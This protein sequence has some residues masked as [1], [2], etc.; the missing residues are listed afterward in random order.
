MRIN[1]MQEV[2]RVAITGLGIVSPLGN[3]PESFF[4]NLVAGN[5]GIKRLEAD[6]TDQLTTKIAAQASFDPTQHFTRQEL[7]L[8]DRVSQFALY[9]A[10]QALKDA[11]L[12]SET[13]ILSKAGVNM[14]ISLGGANTLDASYVRLYREG[15]NTLKPFTILMGMS[16]AA[17]SQIALKYGLCGPS[18]TYS[19]ACSS[20]SV[21]IGEAFRQIQHGYVDVM[22]AGGSE[23]QLTYGQI[24]AWEGLRALGQEDADNPA[25]S[26]K[27]F[28]ANRT[29]LVLGEGSA[30]LV[31]EELEH[32]KARG[33][34]IYAELSGYGIANDSAHITQPSVDGQ[35]AAITAALN[36]ASLEA[37]DIGYINA[38]GTGTLLND[39]TET[40][41]IKQIFGDSASA[42]PISSTKSMHGHLLGA[43]GAVELTATILAM[44]NST[45]P[46]TINL[47]QP[48][49]ACDLDYVPNTA[50]HDVEVRHAMSNSFA[51]GGTGVVLVISK[52]VH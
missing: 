4:A 47:H 18:L 22:L 12:E 44:N 8:L 23:A 39:A 21:A 1:N 29:G 7:G 27:P 6:F 46:P 5:S 20:S 35:A 38:H 11:E 31:L 48:D 52:E 26:C 16:N 49:P 10:Q 40:A 33:A 41:A 15:A 32:A 28:S 9:A 30:V 13:Q 36:S 14:G 50:R 51:F 45:L 37:S 25:A 34:H 3:T 43:S 17:A 19:I 42:P 24:R 2:R